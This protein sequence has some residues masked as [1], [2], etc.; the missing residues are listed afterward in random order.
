MFRSRRPNASS[1][2]GSGTF[3]RPTG[4]LDFVFDSYLAHIEREP[5]AFLDWIDTHYDEK[6]L[7][8]RFKANSWANLM[9]DRVM[10]RE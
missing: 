8:K 4:V 10:R 5:I 6:A 9:V 2:C 1:V 3:A 7:T